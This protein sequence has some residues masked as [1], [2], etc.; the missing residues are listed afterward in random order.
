MARSVTR[1]R[2]EAL[3][4]IEHYRHDIESGQRGFQDVASEFSDC[5]SSA[6]GGDLGWFKEGQM[7]PLFEA[8]AFTLKVMVGCRMAV[9][10]NGI[11]SVADYNSSRGWKM[12]S[13]CV[14]RKNLL[15]L[16]KTR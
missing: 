16:T 11:N 13:V 9:V 12:M 8:A 6:D 1:S 10:C 2:E 5:S 15:K 3:D 7:Q 14:H 4:L